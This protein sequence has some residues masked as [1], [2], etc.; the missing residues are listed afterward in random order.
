MHPSTRPPR[1]VVG[2][3]FSPGAENAVRRAIDVVRDNGAELHVV[4]AAPRVPR[5]IARAFL[6][7]T[8]DVTPSQRE[9]LDRVVAAA[10]ERGVEAKPHLVP[11]AAVQVLTHVAR[12]VRAGLVV[13]GAR[14]RVMPDAVVG[15]TAERVATSA[16]V[17]VLIVR[18]PAGRPYRKVIVAADLDSK[19]GASVE[20]ARFVAPSAQLSVLHAFEGT[21][22]TALMLH[23]ATRESLRRY[24]ADARRE[25]RAKMTAKLER[26]GLDSS[27]LRLRHG[28]AERVLESENMKDD[29]LLV[30]QRGRSVLR[31]VFL[32]SVS[33]WVIARGTSDVLLV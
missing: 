10:R 26:A 13:V 15:S 32:G 22:E 28:R 31:R 3:D 11:G 1:V 25:A 18:K 21:H 33:R 30:L 14:R 9:A 12:A 27:V 29:V 17:P 4:H 6:D 8:G 2:T 5:A 24:R 16:R 20:A 23:G 7:A 19:L